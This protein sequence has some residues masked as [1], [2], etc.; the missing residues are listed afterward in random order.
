MKDANCSVLFF[1]SNQ[2]KR[3]IVSL[4]IRAL[5]GTVG[6]DYFFRTGKLPLKTAV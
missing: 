3:M 4:P 6:R 1:C 2:S 5:G